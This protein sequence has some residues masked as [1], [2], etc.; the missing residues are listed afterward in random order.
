MNGHVPVRPP[1]IPLTPSHRILDTL[2]P[3][4]RIEAD[5]TIHVWQCSLDDA[6]SCLDRFHSYLDAEERLRASRFVHEMDRRRYIAAHGCLRA[7]LARYAGKPPAALPLGRSR[8]GKPMLLQGSGFA[9][10]SFNMSHSHGRMF[11]A[12]AK[13]REVGAD[14]E[15]VREDVETLKLAERF[16]TRAEYAALTAQP[17]AQQTLRFFQYWVAKEAVLKG[18][19]RGLPSLG[20]CEVDFSVREPQTEIRI[21]AG[22][23]MDKGWRVQW[24]LCGLGWT[25]AVAYRGTA[26]L[27]GMPE[28]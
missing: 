7:L 8:E 1:S 24:P 3:S 4:L 2:E 25:A 21:L 18:Q 17:S 9:A 12:V 28:R 22:S 14:L 19:G 20:E 23:N 11:L 27:Q 6:D 10:V 5:G 13:H 16:Y 15:L 26:I